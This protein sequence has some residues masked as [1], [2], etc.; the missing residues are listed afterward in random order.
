MLYLVFEF[1]LAHSVVV[2]EGS[3]LRESLIHLNSLFTV[4]EGIT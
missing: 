1:N 4:P 2:K 3:G